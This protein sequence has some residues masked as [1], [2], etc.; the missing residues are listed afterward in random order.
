MR[1]AVKISCQSFIRR[2]I[3]IIVLVAVTCQLLGQKATETVNTP[4]VIEVMTLYFKMQ[5]AQIEETFMSNRQT[6]VY[7]DSLVAGT[8][9]PVDSIT[10]IGFSSPEG[11]EIMN[12]RFAKARSA[13]VKNYLIQ[14]YPASL[15]NHIIHTYSSGEDWEGLRKA[16]QNDMHIPA[17]QQVLDILNAHI[18]DNA[19]EVKLKTLN[20][21]KPYAYIVK[22]MLQ[23]LRR[24]TIRIVRTP[25]STDVRV[26]ELA[27]TL[28]SSSQAISFSTS[29][30]DDLFFD[31]DS[32]DI[33]TVYQPVPSAPA[34]PF[35]MALK[36]NML[37]DLVLLPN[38]E[39]EVYFKQRWSVNL[40]FQ[41]AWWKN[42]QK[43][44]FY[45][46]WTAGPEVRYWL[47]GDATFCGHYLGAYAST[48]VYDLKYKTEGYWSDYCYS[49]GLSWG[50]VQPIGKRLALEFGLGVG[51]VTTQYKKYLRYEPMGAHYYYIGT[52]RAGYFGPTKAK[53]A[54]V[55]RFNIGKKNKNVH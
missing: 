10:I 28:N 49:A 14:Q 4:S 52:N 5:D 34:Y 21:G 41:I 6:L 22:N 1:F 19:R 53:V 11:R 2:G 8:N 46:I 33:T 42:L 16:V 40:E 24:T 30:G 54:L 9:L 23:H 39:A 47:R 29:A 26:P 17:R 32:A 38:I 20:A 25:L 7:I 50:Y 27:D 37:Y 45:Q 36:T 35:N 44:R 12:N 55:W 43:D 13:Q 3:S 51:Y 15:N 18:S 31:S 48:A